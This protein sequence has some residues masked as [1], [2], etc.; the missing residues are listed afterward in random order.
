MCAVI[1]ADR[2]REL[3]NDRALSQSELA[4]RVGVRQPTIFKL[5][6]G[7]SRN[8]VYLPRIASE[9][10]TTIAYLTGE[11]DDP[12]GEVPTQEPI[13][14]ET[15]EIID[16]LSSLA[17]ADRRA[18][19][20][21]TRLMAGLGRWDDDSVS[22]LHAPA[23][24]YRAEP[25]EAYILP[26]EGALAQMFEGLL[27]GID[28]TARVGEQALLLA[29]RLPIGLSQLQDLLPAPRPAAPQRPAREETDAGPAMPYRGQPR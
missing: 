5:T 22:T 4:R 15:R 9:L 24:P 16:C 10:G 6:S 11:T 28:P 20:R 29:R 13:D 8:S 3:L 17:P 12:D 26:S 1:H 7:N 2:L 19:L 18:W 23:M 25:R 14:S 27:A 21:I